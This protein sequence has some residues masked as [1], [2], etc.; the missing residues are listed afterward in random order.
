MLTCGVEQAGCW[1]LLR[2]PQAALTHSPL[3][4]LGNALSSHAQVDDLTIRELMATLRTRDRGAADAVC[5]LLSNNART[6]SVTL[7]G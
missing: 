5:Q 2:T 6:L 7:L 1:A 3:G 4:F